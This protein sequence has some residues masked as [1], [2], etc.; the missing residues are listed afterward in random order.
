MENIIR[1][2]YKHTHKFIYFRSF[3]LES[4]ESG[5]KMEWLSAEKTR[6]R[7]NDYGAKG[8]PFLCAVNYE[9]TEVFVLPYPLEEKKSGGIWKE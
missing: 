1:N 9:L 2:G 3:V 6:Q 4:K 8:I 7:M 5:R